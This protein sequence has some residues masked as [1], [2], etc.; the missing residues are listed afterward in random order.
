MK[1]L[2]RSL[3][4]TSIKPRAGV[5]LITVNVVNVR[6]YKSRVT[7]RCLEQFGYGPP[8]VSGGVTT[9][10]AEVILL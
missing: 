4:L 3:G 8:L 1:H 9:K 5:I 10:M 7:S 6:G 2:S